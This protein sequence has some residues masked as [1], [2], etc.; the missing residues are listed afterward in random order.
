[1]YSNVQVLHVIVSSLCASLNNTVIIGWSGKCALCVVMEQLL[2][3]MMCYSCES[4]LVQHYNGIH[5]LVNDHN[6]VGRTE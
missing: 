6:I 3:S 2:L 4:A 1:M 5:V